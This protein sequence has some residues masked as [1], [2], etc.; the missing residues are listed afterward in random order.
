MPSHDTFSPEVLRTLEGRARKLLTQWEAQD[1]A[2][3]P[4]WLAYC[5]MQGLEEEISTLL[6]IA[7]VA[8]HEL[9]YST[10]P[11]IVVECSSFWRHHLRDARKGA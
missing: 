4:C 1:T 11:D 5:A 6:R 8:R 3:N 9:G 7:E 10:H 2:D